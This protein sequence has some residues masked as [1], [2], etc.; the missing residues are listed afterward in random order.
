P[1]APHAVGTQRDLMI[2]KNVGVGMA[3]MAGKTGSD[4]GL[5]QPTGLGDVDLPVVQVRSAALL[6]REQFIPRGIVDYAGNPPAFEFHSQR[7]AKHRKPVGEIRS[8][9][10]RIDIPTVIAA[11]VIEAAFLAQNV[12]RWPKSLDPP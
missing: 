4:E 2:E 9:I 5:G 3:L 7:D 1:R 11:T 10:Q 6:G 12:V 8:S